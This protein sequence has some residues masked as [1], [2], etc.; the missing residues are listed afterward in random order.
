MHH[1]VRLGAGLH[2]AD[3]AWCD[4]GSTTKNDPCDQSDPN[5]AHRH[6]GAGRECHHCQGDEPAAVE[7][8]CHQA[9]AESCDRP[10][11]RH[12]GHLAM[13]L[14]A[15]FLVAHQLGAEQEDET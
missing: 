12:A 13:H 6:L 2:L 10:L 9:V 4:R 14:E 11:A 1:Q 3:A 7:R 15:E 5:V 8:G